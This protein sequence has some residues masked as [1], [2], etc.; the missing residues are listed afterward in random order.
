MEVKII[1]TDESGELRTETVTVTGVQ[2]GELQKADN[3]RKFKG[4]LIDRT[5]KEITL[6]DG[7]KLNQVHYMDEQDERGA[8][9]VLEVWSPTDDAILAEDHK[10]KRESEL[11]YEMVTNDYGTK[12]KVK[13]IKLPDG[14]WS[15]PKAKNAWKKGN[16]VNNRAL[17]VQAASTLYMGAYTDQTA[18]DII[19]TAEE[20][21]KW[22][23]KA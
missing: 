17:A 9:L 12:F 18:A 10:A 21:Y 4:H 3:W 20:L 22:I 16:M 5:E 13:A 19:E 7:K 2:E 15:A 14:T 11:Y 23:E 1:K 8:Q 6:K